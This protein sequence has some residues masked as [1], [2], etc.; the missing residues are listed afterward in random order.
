MV[1]ADIYPKVACS[2][3]VFFERVFARES[4]MLKFPEEKRKWGQSKG[5]GRGRGERRENAVFIF[6][7]PPP[8][9][10]SFALASAVRVTNSTLPNLPLS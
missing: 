1:D 8:P 10:P 7:P 2:A 3:G 4:A 9:F 6:S 5:A